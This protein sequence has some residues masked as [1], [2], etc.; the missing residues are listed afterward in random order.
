VYEGGTRVPLLARWPGRIRAGSQSEA[1]A[2]LTDLFATFAD[3][4]GVDLPADAGED[5]FSFL[6]ALLNTKPR[7]AV[8]QALVSDSFWN[9]LAIRKGHWKL[10][11]SQ[12]SG[13][14]TSERI[15][16][17][18]DKPPGQLYHLGRD[19]SESVNEYERHPE[20]VAS[21][22]ALLRAYQASG[23]STPVN[24]AVR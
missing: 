11:L 5:S 3:F 21:L 1:L 15:P 20:I 13:G 19:I 18:P 2:A 24:R 4:F 10:I 12:T 8:R 17:D 14:V 6:G 16:Y 22:T 23:R 9:T 7:Q